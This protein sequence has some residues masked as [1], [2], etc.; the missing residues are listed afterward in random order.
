MLG[1]GSLKEIREADGY[2]RILLGLRL[3]EG[4]IL[5]LSRA[6]GANKV[7]VYQ[8]DVR[9]LTSAMPDRTIN[10][11]HNPKSEENLSRYLLQILE[12]DARK[13]LKNARR[14]L[15]TLSFRDLAHLC[16][17]NETQMAAPRSPVLTSGQNTNA[18]A[19]KS[20]FKFLMTGVDEVEGPKGASDVEKKIDKG[21]I[22]LL[23]ELI[24][25]AHNRLT[26]QVNESELGDQM[27]RL[28]ASLAS[29]SAEASELVGRRSA[30]VERNRTLEVQ[31]TDNRRRA[32]EV[33]DLLTRFGLLRQQYE[34]DLVRLKMVAEAGTLLGYF[35]IGTCVFCGAPPEHQQPGHHLEET[36]QLQAAVTAEIRKTTELHTDLLSTIEDL[37]AQLT[38]LNTDHAAIQTEAASLRRALADLD[39]SLAPLHASTQEL[40]EARSQIQADLAVH[41][42]IQRL[43]DVKA[44][45]SSMPPTPPPARPDGI[46]ASDIADFERMIQET[47]L[48]WKVPGENRVTYNQT[49][50]EIIVDGRERRSRGKGMRSIIHAAFSTA[51]ARY[52][53]MRDLVH[54]GFVVLDSPVLTYREPTDNDTELTYN[55]VEHFY[56]G[57]INDFPGQVVV[58]E[59]GDPPR[60]IDA[61]AQVYPFSTPGSERP[62]FFPAQD[63][64]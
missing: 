29:I 52:T 57:L 58:I 46:P 59:N 7:D 27:R 32:S 54:P 60:D 53:A 17:I 28:E 14:E 22:D 47:L 8:R 35:R 61:Y 2:T 44:G 62:G 38:A 15:R 48:S 19:E 3:L 18:T 56:R 39:Q 11:K 20:V 43:E 45:L 16:V 1:A 64:S 33:N 24:G 34:S 55:V 40:L 12:S 41:A 51:L 26:L 37:E 63:E 9:E 30:Q 21:K 6:P 25:D 5:T 4:Q 31:T 23:D 10:V 36:T 13:I 42:Q 50:A 49:T